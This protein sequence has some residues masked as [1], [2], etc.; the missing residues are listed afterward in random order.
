MTPQEIL[1]KCAEHNVKLRVIN[2]KLTPVGSVSL[3][4]VKI[5][6][7]FIPYKQ[8]LID[9]IVANHP[10]M[11]GHAES[12]SPVQPSPIKLPN[13][14]QVQGTPNERVAR[15]RIPCVSLGQPLEKVSGCGC[16]GAV[17]HKCAIFEKCRRTGNYTDIAVCTSCDKY[18][19]ISTS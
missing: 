4:F 10:D 19:P 12:A 14:V 1:D 15:L 6:A 13:T 3:E 7:Q 16:N 2:N 11:V 5:S 9:Y 18:E 17:I 8:A